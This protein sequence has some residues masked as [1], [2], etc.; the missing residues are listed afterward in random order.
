MLFEHPF[1]R[2]AR[3]GVGG[4]W[5]VVTV[6]NHAGLVNS[7]GHLVIDTSYDGMGSFENGR[8]PVFRVHSRRGESNYA[9]R[10]AIIDTAGNFIVPFGTYEHIEAIQDGYYHARLLRDT[11]AQERREKILD[12]K[13]RVVTNTSA[14]GWYI[15]EEEFRDGGTPVSIQKP[16]TKKDSIEHTYPDSYYGVMDRTGKLLFSDTSWCS[17]IPF[18]TG[19]AFAGYSTEGRNYANKW[20]LIDRGGR[21]VGPEVYDKVYYEDHG[22]NDAFIDGVAFVS[23]ND[24]WTAI[25]TNGRELFSPVNLDS[26]T[27]G[28][29]IRISKRMGRVLILS[30]DISTEDESYS[31]KYGIW[32]TRDGTLLRPIW[33]DLSVDTAVRGL[34]MVMNRGR[35]V[36]CSHAWWS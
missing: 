14:P 22:R 33:Y 12:R 26:A 31:Y 3:S 17:F 29:N 7:A 6:A 21:R 36:H 5:K 20:I 24:S 32:D 1:V 27:D 18:S 25:D 13:G 2:I 11:S 23:R 16:R 28:S 19:R 15:S 8:A 10:S 34:N 9:S 4:L 30:E 35:E